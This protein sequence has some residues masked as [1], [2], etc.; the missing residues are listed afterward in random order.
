MGGTIE[1][2][3]RHVRMIKTQRAIRLSVRVAMVLITLVVTA[4]VVLGVL[5]WGQFKSLVEDRL[6][7]RIGQS[8]SIG[9]MAREAVFSLSPV[10]RLTNVVIAQPAWAGPGKL[11]KIRSVRIGF[12]VLPLLLGDLRP[13]T[14]AI[15]GAVIDLVRDRDGRENWRAGKGDQENGGSPSIKSLDLRNFTIRYR[16]SVQNRFL[17][18]RVTATARGVGVSGTGTIRGAPVTVRA[19]AASIIGNSASWPFSAMIDGRDLKMR[20]LG[21]MARPLDTRDMSFDVSARASDLKMVDAVIEAGLFGTQPVQLD[22]HAR[23]VGMRWTI[24]RLRGRIGASPIAGDL[25]VTKLGGRTLL[26]GAVTSTRLNFDD[27]SSDAGKADALAL[28]RA[29]GRKIVP[30]ARVNIRKIDTT[31]GRIRFDIRQIVGGRRPSSITS[32]RGVVTIDHQ[33]MRVSDFAIGLQKGVITGSVIVDQRGGRAKPIVTLDLRLRDSSIAALAGGDD[34]AI[35]AA[36]TGRVRLTGVGSTV[37]EAVGHANGKIGLVATNGAIPAKIAAMMGF[38]L[39]RSLTKDDAELARLR[40]AIVRFDV[41]N[42]LGS[43]NPV[44]I[45]TSLSQSRA[46]GTLR[47][48]SESLALTVTGAPKANPVL[49]LPGSVVIGGTLLDPDIVVPR[50]IKS[51]GNILKGIGRALKGDQGPLAINVNCAALAAAALR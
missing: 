23:H 26:D 2:I 45:D 12:P 50:Q 21:A 34:G 32:M 7:G 51:L 17:D 6:S 24:D 42:G 15:D 38:D 30:N 14:V 39:G 9:T 28:E 25:V 29:N 5:P 27:F 48:P 35:D 22:A 10:I 8:V 44:L 20:V 19:K 37:R 3:V 4:I 33:L 18:L 1:I 47:F 43:A 49:R 31:D 16:D 41:A 13:T 11:A 46:Q 40:C 36:L